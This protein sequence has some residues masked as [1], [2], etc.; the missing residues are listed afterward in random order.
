M[1][2]IT[3]TGACTVSDT[4]HAPVPVIGSL[5]PAFHDIINCRIKEVFHVKDLERICDGRPQPG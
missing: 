5:F 1:Q 3:G 2:P 4:N